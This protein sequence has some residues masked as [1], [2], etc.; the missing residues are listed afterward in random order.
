[1]DIAC[2]WGGHLMGSQFMV[3]TPWVVFKS[4]IAE[5]KVLTQHI[6]KTSVE[7]LNSL[8]HL[9]TSILTDTTSPVNKEIWEHF[10][11]IRGQTAPKSTTPTRSNATGGMQT[12]MTHKVKQELPMTSYLWHWK[13]T[14]TLTPPSARSLYQM[15]LLGTARM[16]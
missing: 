12:E 11:C 7:E 8:T 6:A 13:D 4:K 2:N 14:P 5:Q 9:L 1:M 15:K 10:P 3:S 16:A